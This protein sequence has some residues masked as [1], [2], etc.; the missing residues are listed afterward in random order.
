MLLIA[1]WFAVT[2]ASIF[3]EERKG[4]FWSRQLAT[5]CK[6]FLGFAL[7]YVTWGPK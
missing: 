2:A 7:A 1:C 4:T 5:A 6:V 3:N